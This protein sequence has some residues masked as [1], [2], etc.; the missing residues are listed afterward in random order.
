M[1][2][3]SLHPASADAFLRKKMKPAKPMIASPPGSARD[4]DRYL[5]DFSLDS[6]W[7][8]LSIFDRLADIL[9]II[10]GTRSRHLRL[11]WTPTAL[12]SIAA[13]LP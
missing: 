12:T 13:Q 6:H 1:Q 5:F 4:H 2:D 3:Q 11:F 7:L 9:P 10:K 8:H